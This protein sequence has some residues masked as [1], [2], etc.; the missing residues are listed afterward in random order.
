[1]EIGG[2]E[3]VEWI[4]R[5]LRGRERRWREDSSSAEFIRPRD[6]PSGEDR[7]IGEA[8]VSVLRGAGASVESGG[9]EFHVSRQTI[10]IRQIEEE[11]ETHAYL[12]RMLV[13]QVVFEYVFDGTAVWCGVS[14]GELW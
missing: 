2:E 8:K 3:E 14:Y 1:M 7:G 6:F 10:I 5:C 13:S 9:I 12:L 4:L 11:E